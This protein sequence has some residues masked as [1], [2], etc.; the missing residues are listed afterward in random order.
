MTQRKSPKQWGSAVWWELSGVACISGSGRCKFLFAKVRA[1]NTGQP[2]QS[3]PDGR[4]PAK[5][6][7]PKNL[8]TQSSAWP[9]IWPFIDH[10]TIHWPFDHSFGNRERLEERR[11]TFLESL[12]KFFWGYLWVSKYQ[13]FHISSLVWG[14]KCATTRAWGCLRGQ[15]QI[16]RAAR[17][18]ILTL[19][20]FIYKSTAFRDYLQTICSLCHLP[21]AIFPILPMFF[22]HVMRQSFG[23]SQYWPRLLLQ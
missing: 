15:P 14:K 1:R 20:P 8:A 22:F 6:P 9:F 17:T 10:L 4:T 13:I 11:L 19:D 5:C 12:R 16:R 2:R 23:A 21:F 7:K 18:V 3:P